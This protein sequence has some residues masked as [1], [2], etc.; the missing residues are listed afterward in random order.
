MYKMIMGI[1]YVVLRYVG[2]HNFCT[3]KSSKHYY[4]LL[5]A[6][7]FKIEWAKALFLKV[8]LKNIYLSII[9]AMSLKLEFVPMFVPLSPAPT[10]PQI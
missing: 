6:M 7:K 3:T 8:E 5:H 1:M 4:I 2:Q 10:L 9:V